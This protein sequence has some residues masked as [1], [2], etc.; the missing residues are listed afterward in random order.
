MGEIESNTF[1]DLSKTKIFYKIALRFLDVQFPS[2]ENDSFLEIIDINNIDKSKNN[3]VMNCFDSE[4]TKKV[5]NYLLQ[6][7][8]NCILFEKS[9]FDTFLEN[10]ESKYKE[11]ELD[12]LLEKF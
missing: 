4:N 1:R 5:Y 7:I 2:V 3:I 9:L 11:E 12:I 8:S 6:M 10:V